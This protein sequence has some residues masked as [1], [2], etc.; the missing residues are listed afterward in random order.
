MVG[1]TTLPEL[2]AA[3]DPTVGHVLLTGH[4]PLAGVGWV[5]SRVPLSGDPATQPFPL[6]VT[7]LT[8]DALF[9]ICRFLDAVQHLSRFGALVHQLAKCPPPTV[10]FDDPRGAVRAARYRAFDL[11]IGFDLPHQGEVANLIALSTDQ[12]DHALARLE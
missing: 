2:S 5:E 8:Y 11:V 1:P 7:R 10:S 9:G 4:A 3:L 6:H 12:L